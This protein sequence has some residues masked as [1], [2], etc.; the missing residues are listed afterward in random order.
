MKDVFK[1]LSIVIL[2]FYVLIVVFVSVFILIENEYGISK[3][4]DNYYVIINEENITD[5]YKLG[6]LVVVKDKKISDLKEWEEVFVYK[7]DSKNN[8]YVGINYI[9][10]IHNDDEPYVLLKNEYGIF[11]DDT[12]VGKGVKRIGKL[13]AY[14]EVLSRKWIFLVFIIV[15]CSLLAIYELYYMFRYLIF[16]DKKTYEL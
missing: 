9:D 10:E 15:P 12:I 2:S 13:G 16:G 4:K 5:N 1:V 14:L 11:R 7:S 6:D 3:F 8:V